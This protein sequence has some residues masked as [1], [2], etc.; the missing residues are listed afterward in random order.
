[1]LDLTLSAAPITYTAAIPE[2]VTEAPIISTPC[3]ETLPE[4]MTVACY[5]LCL[6]VGGALVALSATGWFAAGMP[7]L[8][9]ALMRMLH[10]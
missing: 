8:Q 3:D 2:A 6:F 1:M 5:L 10:L 7:S 4:W 9:P